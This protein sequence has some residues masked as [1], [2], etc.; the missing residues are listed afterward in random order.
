MGGGVQLED[1]YTVFHGCLT[2]PSQIAELEERLS[3]DTA[4]VSAVFYQLALEAGTKR[5]L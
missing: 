1:V 5:M 4:T 2:F 3:Y